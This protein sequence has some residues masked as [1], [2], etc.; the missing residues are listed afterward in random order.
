[1]ARSANVGRVS[2]TSSPA[3]G[4]KDADFVS[5]AVG[6]LARVDSEADL[7]YIDKAARSAAHRLWT[8]QSSPAQ[9][10]RVRAIRSATP[11][12]PTGSCLCH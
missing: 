3:E 5:I 12:L 1:M 2:F 6:T 8:S 10:R 4:L 9:S 7:R 11:C